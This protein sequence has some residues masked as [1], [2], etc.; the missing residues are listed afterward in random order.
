MVDP[1]CKEVTVEDPNESFD[2][3][4]DHCDLK[5]LQ[6][7]KALASLKINNS[8]PLLKKGKMP[9]P[10]V[11]P[12]EIEKVRTANKM[13]PRQFLR[14]VEMALLARIL[15][16]KRNADE[17]ASALEKEEA[18]WKLWCKKRLYRVNKTLLKQLETRE[19]R[20]DALE[21]TLA[22]QT[23]D[24]GRL[25]K[26]GKQGGEASGS[27]G[28]SSLAVRNKRA[29]EEDEEELDMSG[30]AKRARSEVP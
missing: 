19:E 13:A 21:T 9:G 22:S 8:L 11:D 23:A 26:L 29:F 28:S 30:G 27:N 10:I 15:D 18:L 25:L 12:V 5:R 14:C 3:L 7:T 1:L 20:I 2:D 16:P 4:R 24:Y 17:G 6:N